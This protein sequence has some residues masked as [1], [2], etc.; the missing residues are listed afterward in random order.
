MIVRK[1]KERET[2]H[3]DSYIYS[4][5]LLLIN[6]SEYYRILSY[7][8]LIVIFHSIERLIFFFD[9]FNKVKLIVKKKLGFLHSFQLFIFATSLSP[10]LSFSSAPDDGDILFS[11]T[12][13]VQPPQTFRDHESQIQINCAVLVVYYTVVYSMYMLSSS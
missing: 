11:H 4:M 7:E 2:L 6:D 1:E 13:A 9:Y 8:S 10:L 12:V 3:F 5:L